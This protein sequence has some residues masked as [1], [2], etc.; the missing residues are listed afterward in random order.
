MAKNKTVDVKIVNKEEAYWT[1]I[2]ETT[3]SEIKTL[4]D[5][6]KFNHFILSNAEKEVEKA[7]KQDIPSPEN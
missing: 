7:K 4:T 5:M 1:N 2:V 3:Q 6:L